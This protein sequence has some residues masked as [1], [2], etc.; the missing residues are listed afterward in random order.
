MARYFGSALLIPSAKPSSSRALIVEP[1]P[2][3][4]C[5]VGVPIGFD[6]TLHV[7]LVPG[8]PAHEAKVNVWHVIEQQALDLMV[9]INP[10]G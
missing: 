2:F 5:V 3:P 7:R 10:L 9:Q 1:H 6:P 4:V 8:G